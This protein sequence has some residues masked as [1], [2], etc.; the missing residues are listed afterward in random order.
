[1]GSVRRGAIITLLPARGR[2]APAM[3]LGAERRENPWLLA[4]RRAWPRL[5]RGHAGT[6]LHAAFAPRARI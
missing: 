1:M 4:A 3:F 6:R 2:T 5:R